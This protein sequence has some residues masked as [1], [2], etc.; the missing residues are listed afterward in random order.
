MSNNHSAEPTKHGGVAPVHRLGGGQGGLLGALSSGA[1]W[2]ERG[3]LSGRAHR[4]HGPDR[5]GRCG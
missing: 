2:C 1:G 4:G 5:F 3:L